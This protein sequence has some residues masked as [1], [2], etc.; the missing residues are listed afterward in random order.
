MQK[1]TKKEFKEEF[2]RHDE[3]FRYSM[4]GRFK[5]DCNYFLGNGDGYKKVLWTGEI[6]SHIDIM[7]R[8]WRSFKRNAK[9]QWLTM[10]EI[11]KYHKDMKL[12]KNSNECGFNIFKSYDY[13]RNINGITKA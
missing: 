5:R 9:P 1:M 6:E 7:I 13:R 2:L 11:K 8:L 12:M 4:L 3:S 10:K